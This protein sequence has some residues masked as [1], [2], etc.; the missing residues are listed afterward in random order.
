MIKPGN[1]TRPTPGVHV[2]WVAPRN[3]RRLGLAAAVALPEFPV[4]SASLGLLVVAV[5]NNLAEE[6]EQLGRP[7][8]WVGY[9]AIV[10]PIMAALA[11]RDT[12]R[13]AHVA[14]LAVLAAA[15]YLVK[16]LHEPTGFVFHD[17][18]GHWGTA[19]AI[20]RS[21]Q[22]F[23]Q[24]PL[25]SV[26]PFYPG[27][28]LLT[29][30]LA[31]VGGMSITTA[32]TIVV[33]MA[34]VCLL[35]G[36]YVAY[37]MVASP[38]LAALAACFY[39]ANPNFLYFDSQF[40][41]ESLAIPLAVMAALAVVRFRSRAAEVAVP[42]LLAAAVV[43][44]HHLTSYALAGFFGIAT[45][46]SRFGRAGT[47][48]GWKLLA[49]FACW[50]A[51]LAAVWAAFVAP[52]VGGYLLPVLRGAVSSV[53]SVLT[54]ER[55]ARRP[56][57]APSADLAPHWERA[58][59]VA[60]VG[61]VVAC[62]FVGI[63]ILWRTRRGVGVA[64]ALA[65]IALVYPVLILF[66]LGRGG[67]E[68]A[69]R[70]TEFSYVGVAFL[71]A[72]CAARAV[73]P[74]PLARRPYR[75]SGRVVTFLAAVACIFIGGVELGWAP[76]ALQPGP[77]LPGANARSITQQGKSAAVWARRFLPAGS[78]I[79]TDKAT[80]LMM[81]S[82]GRLHPQ[83]GYIHGAPLARLMTSPRFDAEDRR[84]IKRDALQYLIVDTRLSTAVP[85]DGF[86]FYPKEP[87][88]YEYRRPIPQSGLTK[89]STA[90]KLDKLYT[91]GPVT[92]YGTRRVPPP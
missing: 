72:L 23:S 32:G 54:G 71:L 57:H 13:R 81:G 49:A 45:L 18:F 8:F 56:F 22:L 43:T 59:T 24:N 74:S 83:L 76:V 11:H 90:R 52:T 30:A 61:L 17:E 60:S 5:A 70:S 46:S 2:R 47:R 75:R 67:T 89:F 65:A 68:L 91:D 80:A 63:G 69:S 79:F 15:L 34:K 39:A 78:R 41:Y 40:S 25:L 16:V 26:S 37:S 29:N 31:S 14:L 58:V 19:Y 77:Y 38:R 84:I 9:L 36:L 33:G 53:T 27:L 10:L 3:R 21:H 55:A 86:Y 51:G 73:G 4:I 6:G 66:R 35:V 7:L 1:R 20:S 64:W 82:Y 12:G 87:D 62:I 50:T 28:E 88:A 44:T 85:A 48:R 92:I 42:A